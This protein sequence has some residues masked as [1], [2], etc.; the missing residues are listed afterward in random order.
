MGSLSRLCSRT[1]LVLMIELLRR[2]L[3][4][5]GFQDLRKYTWVLL[6][7]A[8]GTFATRHLADRLLHTQIP[9]LHHMSRSAH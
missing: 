3:W 8:L 7:L 1:M 4:D 5:E 9:A 6:L 2:F